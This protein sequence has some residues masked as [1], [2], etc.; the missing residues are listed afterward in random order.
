MEGGEGSGLKQF[1][2]LCGLIGI[3]Q[4]AFYFHPSDHPGEE[5][6]TVGQS[7]RSTVIEK[8]PQAAAGIL[9]FACERRDPGLDRV[10][11]KD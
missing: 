1:P 3:W 5:K 7:F 4:V 11:K 6:G 8:L 9:C 10:R 2:N